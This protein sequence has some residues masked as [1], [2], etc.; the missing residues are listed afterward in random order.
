MN[1]RAYYIA[2][3]TKDNGKGFGYRGN[4]PKQLWDGKGWTT[5]KNNAMSFDSNPRARM[6]MR[7]M[8]AD[9]NNAEVIVQ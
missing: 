2:K 5:D 1:T 4:E 8:V 3:Q 7:T 9:R 6:V